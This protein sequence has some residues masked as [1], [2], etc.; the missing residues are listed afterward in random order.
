MFIGCFEISINVIVKHVQSIG[1]IRGFVSSWGGLVKIFSAWSD[2]KL[3]GCDLYLGWHYG[4]NED[5]PGY[6]ESI[7]PI[8]QVSDIYFGINIEDLFYDTW[9]SSIKNV[10]LLKT[11]FAI[12]KNKTICKVVALCKQDIVSINHDLIS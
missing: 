11:D 12:F 9:I 6:I 3:L 2:K 10:I 1:I 4:H 7:C 5:M 8:L